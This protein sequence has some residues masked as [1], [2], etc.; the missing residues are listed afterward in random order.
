[1][2]NF[3]GLFFLISDRNLRFSSLY[4]VQLV[5]GWNLSQVS[6]LSVIDGKVTIYAEILNGKSL[7]FRY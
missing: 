3:F 4:A 2:T 1:M 5:K 6:L 7:Q